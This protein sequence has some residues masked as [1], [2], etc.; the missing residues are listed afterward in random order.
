MYDL[1][2]LALTDLFQLIAVMGILAMVLHN[3]YVQHTQWAATYMPPVAQFVSST[4]PVSTR[5]AQIQLR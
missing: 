4:Q 5:A 1:L 2:Q 3:A